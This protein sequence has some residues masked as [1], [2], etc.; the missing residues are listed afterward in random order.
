MIP[1]GEGQEGVL[2]DSQEAKAW[3]P[4]GGGERAREQ[5]GEGGRHSPRTEECGS[6]CPPWGTACYYW[7]ER[8][9]TGQP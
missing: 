9:V 7:G 2:R 8:E 1:G 3:D 6:P 4:A 5:A